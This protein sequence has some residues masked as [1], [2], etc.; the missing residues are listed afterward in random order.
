MAAA[1]ATARA[2]T[3]STPYA[4]SLGD[5]ARPLVLRTSTG[6]VLTLDAARFTA[7]PD[8]VD[9]TVLDRC[10]GPTL[11]LGCG[12]GRLVAELA[13]RGIPALGIEVAPAAVLLGRAAGAAVLQRS[14]FGRLPGSGRW[15]HALLID[16]N[17]GIGGDPAALLA[18]TREL[19]R[20]GGGELV[21]ETD[22]E[23]VH[24][25]HMVTFEGG[26]EPFGWTRIG[27]EALV[28]VAAGLGFAVRERWSGGGRRFVALACP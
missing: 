18:R 3:S 20:P 13:R 9:R 21:V 12:P 4:E 16:G 25:D 8:A 14:L 2:W 17:I 22:A 28:R 5:P 19:L 15:P 11:D 10:Q 24:E 23:D 7:V 26:D 27:T 1:S 6:Q